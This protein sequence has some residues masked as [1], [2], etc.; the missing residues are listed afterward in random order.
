MT[1]V[2]LTGNFLATARCLIFADGGGVVW[3]FN[4]NTN[5]LTAAS[6]GGGATGSAHP[7]AVI[8]LT[9][10]NGA[11]STYMTSD[12]APALSQ[13][14]APTWTNPHTFNA[15]MTVGS[16]LTDG[17]AS[18]G[19]NGQ[20]LSSTV[21]GVKWV[22]A[23]GGGLSSANPTA[24]I[25]LAAVNGSAGTFMTSDSAPPLSQGIVPTWTGAHTF[26]STVTLQG[27]GND[28][29]IIFTGASAYINASGAPG[30]TIAATH[31]F[32]V[33]AANYNFEIG[34]SSIWT[35]DASGGV[36]QQA[37]TG[38]TS[39]VL[40]G[41]ASHYAQ[42]IV[43]SSSSTHS[44]GL[45]C[46]AGTTG[47]DW[48][49]QWQSYAAGVFATLYGDGG[50]AVGA[51]P[52]GASMGL[53]TINVAGGYYINGTALSFTSL[54]PL[55]TE[56]DLIY[57]NAT[58]APARLAIGGT[59]TF[60]TVAAGIPAWSTATLPGTAAK[61]DLWYASAA[62]VMSALAVGTTGQLLT[63][64][65]GVPAWEA[66]PT[67]NQNTTGSSASCT[68]NAATATSIAGGTANQIPY[69]TGAG[70]TSFFSAS[71]YGVL[72]YG[73]TGVP[74]SIAGAAGVLVGSASAIPAFSL[75]PTLSS[76]GINGTGATGV[77]VTGALNSATSIAYQYSG[78]LGTGVV[79]LYTGFFDA[80]TIPASTTL[81]TLRHFTFL[82]VALS[83]GSVVTTQVGF[84]VP[85][86][87]G[88]G[89]NIAFQGN[90]ASGANRWNAY[91][92]G[93]ADNY[94]QGN[95]LIGTNTD[96]STGAL[97]VTGNTALTGTLAVSGVLT[98]TVA[99]GTAPMAI[100]STTQV[101][102]L[103]AARAG[104]ATIATNIGNAPVGGVFKLPPSST[105]LRKITS[106]GGHTID[107]ARQPATTYQAKTIW[108]Q[109][110]FPSQTGA[111]PFQ[112]AANTTELLAIGSPGLHLTANAAGV[113]QW[114]LPSANPTAALGLSAI[115]GTS[116]NFMRADAA[117]AL[118]QAIVPTWT[119]VHTFSA[120]PVF[121][122]GISTGS[123]DSTGRGIAICKRA[124][125]IE[126]RTSTTTLTNSTQLTYAVPGAGT[127]AFEIV[128]FSYFTTAV[129]D[130]I[131]ANV[132]YSGTFTAV[133]SYVTGL[134]MNGTTTPTGIQPVEISATVNNALVGM[135]LLTYGAS[136]AAATPACHI[137]KGNLIATGAGTLA[138]AFSQSTTGVDTTN[139]G[140]GS[141][142][143]V[144]QLS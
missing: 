137:L 42:Q 136:V 69:Q 61:G 138:F 73:A 109:F 24:T 100:T 106:R 130:G 59:G 25:G 35:M 133:G 85:A 125:S 79:T 38:E 12:S 7:S 4:P 30:L 54:S 29:G 66:I 11:L 124:T 121:S 9:A 86:L 113:P 3:A 15:N 141:Y 46:Q 110:F 68:G 37:A 89:T 104:T 142:M 28:S 18:V 140:V 87:V 95:V 60:L 65:G 48:N 56:G 2:A 17:S 16:T 71:N 72:T 115:P 83:G 74:A 123:N 92:A 97:Q 119:G 43:G 118:S 96:A 107:L 62:N 67:W 64:T 99:V 41:A 101:A 34:G 143:T 122:L 13:A 114:T 131:T 33:S 8:G 129:T 58:P 82:D 91:M 22:A 10:V 45:L 93:S 5:T 81:G 77:N 102:N 120:I 51:A 49:T 32:T 53:G 47:A 27:S 40:Y 52:T 134:V 78:T 127:Y 21:T 103:N 105:W 80:V 84:Y 63:V 75:T 50:L 23:G 117:P 90:V 36:T 70:A 76:L 111:L 88:G 139:L 94:F 39:F 144:T 116:M 57:E 6:S 126:Q 135:T 26:A 1:Q 55:T 98:S 19:T 128:V 20:V 31:A 112:T 108:G 132:N 14:I 44:Y